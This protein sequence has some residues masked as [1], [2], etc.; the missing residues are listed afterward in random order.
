MER[1]FCQ[2]LSFDALEVLVL[3]EEG[4]L[5]RFGA[6]RFTEMGEEYPRSGCLAPPLEL[7]CHHLPPHPAGL[8]LEAG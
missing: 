2:T 6:A 7:C 3:V 1:P 5:S 8:Q 4:P